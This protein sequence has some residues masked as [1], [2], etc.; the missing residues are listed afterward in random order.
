MTMLT[1]WRALVAQLGEALPEHDLRLQED[2]AGNAS[3]GDV[4]IGPPAPIWEGLCDPTDPTGF[5]YSVYVV[6]AL[7]ERAVERLLDKV[8][9]LM[10][11][12]GGLG[13]DTSIT[14][15]QP[16]VFPTGNTDLPCYRI[17]AETTLGDES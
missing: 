14:D 10:L 1:K 9:G 4:L 3:P 16:G 17:D 11:A 5:N 2:L 15:V 7:G 6:E 13:A 12:V 8:P